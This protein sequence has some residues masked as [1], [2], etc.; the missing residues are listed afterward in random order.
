MGLENTHFVNAWGLHA[1]GHY[2]SA[3]DLA[4]IAGVAM[5]DPEFRKIVS[6]KEYTLPLAGGVKN[7]LIK[8]S[9]QLLQDCDWVSGI[10]TGSTPWAGYC[11]VSSGTQDGLTLISVILGAK[12]DDTRDRESKALL[13]Y[14]F[15]RCQRKSLIDQGVVVLDVPLGD[16]LARQVRLVT[17]SPFSRRLLGDGEITAQVKLSRKVAL[18]VKAGEVFGELDFLQG[19]SDIGSVELIA[20]QTVDFPSI[21]LV[22]LHVDGA[23]ARALPLNQMLAPVEN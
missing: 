15:E 18:P 19:D 10:K 21:R 20:A 9:N 1:E 16:L 12:D 4:K 2:S 11:L 22:L 8:T 23:W 14:S 13:E 6:T 17:A 3:R 7:R 5:R